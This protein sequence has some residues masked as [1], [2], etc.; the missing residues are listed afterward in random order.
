M[1]RNREEESVG[2]GLSSICI[3]VYPGVLVSPLPPCSLLCTEYVCTHVH[4]ARA[5]L[6]RKVCSIP[7]R[8]SA[9]L[10]FLEMIQEHPCFQR[11]DQ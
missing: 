11:T 1:W 9:P 2:S 3:P 4:T 5:A 7:C 8:A 10:G 6:G